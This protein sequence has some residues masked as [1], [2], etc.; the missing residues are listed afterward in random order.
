MTKAFDVHIINPKRKRKKTG[1]K[2]ARKA[3]RRKKR[4]HAAKKSTK[5][6][7]T[8]MAKRRP[9]RRRRRA[10]RRAPVAR[11]PARRRRR[12]IANPRRRRRASSYARG[13]I[14]AVVSEFKNSLPRMFGKLVTAWCVRRWSSTAGGI[15]GTAHTSPM[16]GE[17]WSLP[18]YAIAGL[19]ATLGPRFLGRWVN[20]GQFRA[21][22]VDLMVEKMIWTEGIARNSWAVQQF[23]TGDVGYNN[24]IGQAYVDQGGRWNAMQGLVAASP[25]DGLVEASP[26]DGDGD[27]AYGHLLPAGASAG[28]QRAGKYGGSGYTSQYHAAFSR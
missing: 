14:N 2:T 27:Y 12:R 9:A 24:Q 13:G 16:M 7:S 10:V 3:P 18:Q 6:R 11:R 1:K 19:V 21:G 23:G 26:L 15:F 17:G 4:G 8:K 28:T 5:K 20:G 25:L 22:C